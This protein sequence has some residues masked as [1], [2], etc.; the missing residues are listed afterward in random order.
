MLD[1]S[2]YHLAFDQSPVGEYLLSASDDPVILAVNDAFLH[3]VGRSRDDLVGQRLFAAFPGNPDDAGDTGVAPLRESLRRVLATGA[4]DTLPLQRYPITVV[5]ADGSRVFEERWWSARSTPIFGPARELLCIAHRTEDVT[6]KWRVEQALRKAQLRAEVALRIAQLGTFDWNFRT[7][8]IERSERTAQIYAFA[9]HEGRHADEFFARLHPDDVT[10]MQSAIDASLAADGAMEHSFRIRLPDGSVRHVKSMATSERGEDAEWERHIGVMIDITEH[11]QREQ[12]LL[13]SSRRKDEFLAML[14]HE[15]RNPLAPIAAAAYVLQVAHGDAAKIERASAIIDRQVRHMVALVDDLLD[16]ARVTRGQVT[17]AREELD[18]QRAVGEAVEQVRPVIEARRH[19]L[20]VS[21]APGRVL[22]FGDAK[23]L[24]QVITNLL[25]NAAKY[26][27]EGGRIAIDLAVDAATVHLSV[28]DSG[29]GMTP[30]LVAH[31]FDLFVQAERARDRAA[32]GLGIGLPLV[33]SLV[34]L[35]GGSVAAESAGPGHGSRFTVTLPRIVPVER[36]AAA[37][38]DAGTTAQPG[39]HTLS[40]LIVDDNE[41]A[42][43]MLAMM[44]GELG[45]RAV[46]EHHPRHALDRLALERPDVALLDVGLPD[47]DGYQLAATIRERV[48]PAPRLVAITGY[49]QPQDRADA[50]AAGFD[51]H[52]AKP[53]DGHALAAL[54]AA[55]ERAA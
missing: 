27:P 51:E 38:H 45:H 35:H 53:V 50:L 25:T 17:L 55:V 1:A 22:V 3:A 36:A 29:Q 18:L 31:C 11:V 5:Q 46:V 23:R 43:E 28:S 21:T 39:A 40:V 34:E 37:A 54:L 44:V 32:G 9:E 19:Q 14:A 41:D 6:E 20:T 13:E 12:A 48:A 8:E 52:F 26:T 24:V 33:R 2:V 7:G 10:S 30:E 42:A 4:P 47:M 49:G 16:V 15:L